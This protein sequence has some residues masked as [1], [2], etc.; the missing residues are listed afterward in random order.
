MLP[1]LPTRVEHDLKNLYKERVDNRGAEL[2]RDMM[3]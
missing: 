3:V 2:G 1:G